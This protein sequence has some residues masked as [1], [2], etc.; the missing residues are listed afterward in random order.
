MPT[1]ST[2]RGVLPASCS[3]S[4]QITP[5]KT[6][7]SVVNPLLGKLDITPATS[8]AE[9]VETLVGRERQRKQVHCPSPA[10]MEVVKEDDEAQSDE[11]YQPKYVKGGIKKKG[12]PS[13]TK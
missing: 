2:S 7:Q 11:E 12:K 5:V 9:K 3:R 8:D 4:L 6:V 13:P 10:V 1:A